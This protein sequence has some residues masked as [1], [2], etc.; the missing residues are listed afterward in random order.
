MPFILLYWKYL[1]AAAAIAALTLL[2]NVHVDGLIKTAVDKAVIE[3]DGKWQASEQAAIAKSR[4]EAQAKEAAHA[5]DLETI[6]HQHQ[7]DIANAKLKHDKDVADARSGA[8]RLRLPS[9]VCASRGDV[10]GAPGSANPASETT[11]LPA[12]LTGRLFGSADDADDNIDELNTCWQ[13]VA[14][15]RKEIQ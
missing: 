9:A 14:S 15:D 6:N 13:I 12:R 11:A 3:R 2:Y 4:A 1:A 7:Q 8:L 5:K 10:P